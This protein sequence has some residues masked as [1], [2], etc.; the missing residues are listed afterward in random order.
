LKDATNGAALDPAVTYYVLGD[1]SDTTAPGNTWRTAESWPPLPAKPTRYYLH[2]DRSL[3]T[4]RPA[5]ET[6]LTYTYNPTNPVPTV[7]G[8]QLTIP[9]GPM[10]QRRIESRPDVLVFTSAVLAA[11]LEVTGPVT[12]QL[13]VQSDGPD[14]DFFVRLCDVYPDGRSFNLCEGMLRARFR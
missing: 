14:T 10:D 1:V 4:S 8:I 11:P 7:G 2:S 5:R 6:A 12:A 13:W 3:S 9:A